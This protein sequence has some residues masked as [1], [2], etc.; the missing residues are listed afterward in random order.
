[1]KEIM[2]NLAPLSNASE[3][4]IA[5]GASIMKGVKQKPRLKH[6]PRKRIGCDN[7]GPTV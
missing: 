2:T 1:M 3:A 4:L 5:S 7:S 6:K